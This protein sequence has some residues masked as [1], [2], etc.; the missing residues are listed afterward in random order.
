[1][2]GTILS[3]VGWL[4]YRNITSITGIQQRSTFQRN[5]TSMILL[6]IIVVIIPIIP[7]AVSNVYQLITASVIKSSFRAA[8]EQQ[9]QDMTNIVFYGNNASSFY[10]YLI[11]SSSYRRDFLQFIQFWHNEDH[12]NNRVTPATREQNELKETSARAQL[13][14]SNYKI[15]LENII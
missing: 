5:L 13:Q 2:P 4:T 8:V 14:K 1:M 7:F 10:V 12:W 3:I 6:Q 9:V 15:N 11:S